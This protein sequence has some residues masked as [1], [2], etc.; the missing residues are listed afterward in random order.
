MKPWV[1]IPLVLVL[2]SVVN[3]SDPQTLLLVRIL[4]AV[5][6]GFQYLLWQNVKARVEALPDDGA[7]IFV[8]E[9]K[10]ASL[11]G[12]LDGLLG[13]TPESAAAQ[14]WKQTTYKALEAERVAQQ[15]QQAIMGP[16]MNVGMSFYMGIHL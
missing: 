2:Q 15:A 14:K 11:Q 3:T 4:F 9:A 13:S 16:L 7:P 8:K 10:A 5:W 12:L 1:T 6:A